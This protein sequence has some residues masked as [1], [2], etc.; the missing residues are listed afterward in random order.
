MRS[1]SKEIQSFSE[2]IVVGLRVKPTDITE[3]VFTI[4]DERT[5]RYKNTNENFIFGISFLV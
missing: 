1:Q 4:L 5:I 2:N 3:R